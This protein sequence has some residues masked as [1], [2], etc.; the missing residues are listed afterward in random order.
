MF[1]QGVLTLQPTTTKNDKARGLTLHAI[2]QIVG[3]ALSQYIRCSNYH[4]VL[5]LTSLSLCHF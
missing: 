1:A 5:C 3:L 2:F 4:H